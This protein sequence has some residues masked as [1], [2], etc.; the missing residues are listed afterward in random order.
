MSHKPLL[1]FT[2]L[3]AF[4]LCL[5]LSQGIYAQETEP[6]S[7][8]AQGR[9]TMADE[10]LIDPDV[11]EEVVV[12]GTRVEGSG[13]RGRASV[14]RDELDATDQVDM[15]G[16]FDEIDGLSTLGGDDEGNAFSIDGLS[17][18]L[19][20]VTLDG[21][22][23]GQGRGNRGFGAGNLPP[24]MIR[25]I[26][27]YKT[28]VASREEG[29]A[30]G[31][32]NLQL[33]NPVDIPAP[34]ASAKGR[35]GYVA[36]NDLFSPSAS[37]FSSRPSESKKSG[38]MLSVSLTGRNNEFGRQDISTWVQQDFDGTSAYIPNQVRNNDVNNDQ[39][40]M[41]A[42]MALGFRPRPSLDISGK[43]FFSRQQNNTETHSLQHRVERQRNI[44]PLEFDERI[45]S[46]LETSEPSRRNLR[47]AGSNRE[48]RIDSLVLGMD[49]TWRHQGWRLE[50]AVGYDSTT[51]ENDPP[52]QT[53]VF[54]ANSD[55]GY[56]NN[57]DGSLV[58]D[59]PDGFP[60][61]PEFMTN[62]I[63]LSDRNTEDTNRFGGIDV[64][65]PLAEG[66][67]RRISFG[68][69][70]RQMSRSR[71]DSKGR[72]NLVE[73]LLLA[74]VA[75]GELHQTP[76]D[77]LPWPGTDLDLIDSLVRENP[78][79]WE[80]NLLNEYDIERRTDAGY[81]Q[82]DFRASLDDKR[83]MIGNIGARVVNTDTW[84]DGYQSVGETPEPISLKT[85]ETDILPSASVR[86]R[87]AERAALTIGAAKV[88][89]HPSF[90]D[91]AP[92]IRFN[93]SE[94]TA[95]SG[96]PALEPFR[97]N[98]F[99]TEVT[100]SPERGR[101]LIA[102]LVYRDVKSFFVLGEE[103]IEIDDDT[104]L[105]M[106]PVNGDDGSILTS[107]IKLDQNLRR[108]TAYLRNFTLSLA[109]THNNSRTDLNDPFTGKPLPM[110]NTAEHVVKTDLSYSKGLFGGK[111]SYQWR[112][113]SLKSSFSESGL[114][115][116]NQP[117]G[118]LNLNLGW[119]LNEKLQ[120]SFDARNLLNE[121]QIQS[122][123]Y[124]RQLLRIT[125]R[126]RSLSATLRARW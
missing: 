92:G 109:Y 4:Y 110:P 12:T 117:V 99:M 45:V 32:V 86:M 38:Y 107:S 40:S 48:D 54:D 37:F 35:L 34:T 98:Q 13:G 71:R 102:K 7:R 1:S 120:L 84:I 67:F 58:M 22:G 18:N 41:F 126:N 66:F 6:G 104:F 52:S 106:R 122:T 108:M 21:Q 75:S 5:G 33:R 15:E 49:F 60:A 31:L 9:E 3:A 103:S 89:T 74:D 63:S 28:P 11:L 114:S 62:R 64:T 72:V 78:I 10:M 55:F 70:S 97:A 87:I 125:E 83:F 53:V 50:G 59:Y 91:L 56:S 118:S 88:M 16:F 113:R 2:V 100:W 39:A 14:G 42:G 116:W 17:A 81:V 76:W 30:G 82:A 26:D 95:K 44:L 96:N 68:A 29:G 36:E 123:D 19:S 46:K 25:R 23:F 101:R 94:K 124:D 8:D 65:R 80:D 85:R 43:L 69:K 51:N 27:V 61:V 115:T 119:K 47:V 93:H 121:E 73:D 105:I 79:A 20:K 111:I 90:N 57:H 77:S 24:E 112:G